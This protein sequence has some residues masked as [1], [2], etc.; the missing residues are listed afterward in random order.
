MKDLV[1]RLLSY[2]TTILGIVALVIP[3]LVL[4][5]VIKPENQQPAIDGVTALWN[6]VIEVVSSISGLV[7]IF[8]HDAPPKV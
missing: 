5:K 7:L 2:K 3:L 1:A 8:S 4:F 6:G